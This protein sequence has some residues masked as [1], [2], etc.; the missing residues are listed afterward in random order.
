MATAAGASAI[1]P[2]FPTQG[3]SP[4][5]LRDTLPSSNYNGS[6]ADVDVL[7]DSLETLVV[8]VSLLLG[9]LLLAAAWLFFSKGIERC[10]RNATVTGCL[11]ALS[12]LQYFL[13]KVSLQHSEKS[14]VGFLSRKQ[15]ECSTAGLAC[16]GLRH[17]AV[18][19]DGNRRYGKKLLAATRNH[20]KPASSPSTPLFQAMATSPLNGHKAGGEKLME[21]IDYC[22]ELNIEMLTVYA[23]ST[24]NWNRPQQEIDVLMYLFEH[25][26]QKIRKSAHKSGIFIRFI[27]TEP[28]LLPPRILSLMKA[29]EEETR[30]VTPR[31][32]IVNCCVSYGGR[33]EIVQA[34][35]RIVNRSASDSSSITEEAIQ[36]E[37]LRS[38]TQDVHEEEDRD[39]IRQHGGCEP[40]VMLRTSGEARTSNFLMYESAYSE[41]VFVEKS[42]PEMER[43]DLVQVVHEYSQRQ[44]RF[45]K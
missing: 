9:L 33:S 45:G 3:V 8:I 37:M 41:L 2:V 20:P 43:A 26:F 30:Q 28:Q 5:W 36:A 1:F 29:V 4:L 24:E 31:K 21:F 25:F 40:H 13:F 17:L 18:I 32:I 6:A 38:I 27:A 14:G 35:R 7:I 15:A 12:G 23:F 44:R 19:M 34:C 16:H 39:I 22:V 10:L 42:W 11:M